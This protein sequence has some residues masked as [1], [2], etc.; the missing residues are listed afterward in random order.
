M[1]KRF[2]PTSNYDFSGRFAHDELLTRWKLCA[3]IQV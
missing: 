1:T 3:I 2:V